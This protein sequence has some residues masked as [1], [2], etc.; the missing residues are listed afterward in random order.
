VSEGLD[1]FSQEAQDADLR[2]TIRRLQGRLSKAEATR[3]EMVAAV[4]QAAKDAASGMTIPPIPPARSPSSGRIGQANADPEVA[5]AML[6]DWQ[7]GKRTPSYDSEVCKERVRRYAAKVVRLIDLQRAHHPVD[8]ARVYLLGDL[9]E[10]EE[11]FPGQSHRITASLYTQLFDCA[12]L[13]AEVVRTIAAAV[14]KVRV[15]GVIGNHG[16]MG[17]PVRRSYHPESNFDAMAYNIAR[18]LVD[19]PRIEWPET[20]VAGERA[21]YGTD[22]VLGNR[23][24]LFH[25]DQ[26]KSASFGIPWYGFG[27]KLLG[28]STSVA[29][30]RFAAS[31]HWHQAV[32]WQVNDITHWGAGST[33]SGNTYAQEYLASGG[34]EPSQWLVFMNESGPTA[35]YQ[36]RVR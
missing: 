14:D 28:W 33:E 8:E 10:G 3:E 1:E 5:I 4:Y 19:D 32:R 20:F 34:Q 18:M 13:I 30:F 6:A 36:V 31:G 17:G 15:V 35:E 2:A 9:L 24:F 12:Q 23:W 26:V 21:W 29:P 22:E 25:G 7:L 27:K 11:I 16:S